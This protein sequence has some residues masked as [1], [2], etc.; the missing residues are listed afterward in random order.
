MCCVWQVATSRRMSENV[1][2]Q[3]QYSG[4]A[5]TKDARSIVAVGSDS[6]KEISDSQVDTGRPHSRGDSRCT[7]QLR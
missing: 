4:V 1:I 5:I 2:K 3:C 6:I 7:T